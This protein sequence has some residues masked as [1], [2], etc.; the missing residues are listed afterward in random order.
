[1]IDPIRITN[2]N[3]VVP[4]LERHIYKA[5]EEGLTAIKVTAFYPVND[6]ESK[7]IIEICRGFP[8]VLDAKWLYGTVIFKV[9]LKH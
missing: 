4:V 5:Y 3:Q 6:A 7:R 2:K 1:M 8:A 9:Y